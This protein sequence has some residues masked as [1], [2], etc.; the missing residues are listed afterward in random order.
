MSDE[1]KLEDLKDL[2]LGEAGIVDPI[3]TAKTNPARQQE[4]NELSAPKQ[5]VRLLDHPSEKYT[6][7][8]IFITTF[9]G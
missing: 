8:F 2:P 1:F 6:R 9:Y 3:L 4:V 7:F 5:V